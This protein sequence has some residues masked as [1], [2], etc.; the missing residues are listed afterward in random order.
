MWAR[1]GE[2]SAV[3]RLLRHVRSKPALRPC[4][5]SAS[6]AHRFHVLQAN[7]SLEVAAEA[8]T[9]AQSPTTSRADNAAV[10]VLL[11]E[12]PSPPNVPPPPQPAAEPIPT[13]PHAAANPFSQP[14]ATSEQLASSMGTTVDISVAEIVGMGFDP[15]HAAEALRRCGA[16]TGAAVQLLLDHPDGLPPQQTQP[17]PSPAPPPVATAFLMTQPAT[18]QS[19][20]GSCARATPG[21]VA[22]ASQGTECAPSVSE[23]DV[24]ALVDMGFG[25]EQARAAL[26]R[27]KGSTVAA[28]SLL[29]SQT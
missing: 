22:S 17:P 24:W 18:P 4:I 6:I 5:S 3:F 1:E 10:S 7:G 28:I 9:T 20:A 29:L 23:S 25:E 19:T 12:M 13:V 15:A 8:L 27:T 2:F 26:S 21:A 11:Q 16:D 14:S